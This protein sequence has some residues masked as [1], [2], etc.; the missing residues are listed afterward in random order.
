VSIFKIRHSGSAVLHKPAEPITEFGGEVKSLAKHLRDTLHAARNPRGIGLAAPQIGVSKRVAVV[1][2]GGFREV[3]V[4]PAILSHS[5]VRKSDLEGCLSLPGE[6][7]I[8]NRFVTVN[9]QY[10]DIHGGEHKVLLSNLIARVVQHEIDHL[11]G[12]LIK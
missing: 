6:S 7:K 11:N 9:L 1:E 4:N 10:W 12:I 8:K 2:V 5:I 3:L